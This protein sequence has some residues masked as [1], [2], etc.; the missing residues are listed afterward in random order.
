[1]L[2]FAVEPMS[3]K[4]PSSGGVSFPR[5]GWCQRE[6]VRGGDDDSCVFA[7]ASFALSLLP[8]PSPQQVHAAYQRHLFQPLERE[9]AKAQVTAHRCMIRTR[10]ITDTQDLLAACRF[11]LLYCILTHHWQYAVVVGQ[12]KVPNSSRAS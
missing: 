6:H 5:M 1:M 7:D 4:R 8:L 12:S 3:E 2:I 11:M 9:T 10:L